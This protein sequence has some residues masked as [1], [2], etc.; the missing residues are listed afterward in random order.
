MLE[1]GEYGEASLMMVIG[2]WDG[3]D[4]SLMNICYV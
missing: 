1:E 2:L 4:V 3:V